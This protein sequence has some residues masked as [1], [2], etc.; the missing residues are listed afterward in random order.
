MCLLIHKCMQH[1]FFNKKNI[2]LLITIKLFYTFTFEINT[3]S[4]FTKCNLTSVVYIAKSYELER[5]VM[6]LIFFD[7]IVF[8]F[9]NKKSKVLPKW[10]ELNWSLQSPSLSISKQ[11]VCNCQRRQWYYK[12]AL[13]FNL[14][15]Y[16]IVITVCNNYFRNLLFV[17]E[18]R[19]TKSS[20]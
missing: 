10:M 13:H 19:R 18:S 11:S 2:L 1:V 3:I 14:L 15:F 8:W 5:S 12:S 9:Q 4:I 6:K 16:R 17:H 20:S 7:F